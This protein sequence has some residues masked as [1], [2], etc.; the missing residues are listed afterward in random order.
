MLYQ[1]RLTNGEPDS[2]SSGTWIAPDGTATHLR[3][4]DFRMMP[5]AFWKSNANGAKYPIGGE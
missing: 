2:S 5:I 4:P 1:M 3:S